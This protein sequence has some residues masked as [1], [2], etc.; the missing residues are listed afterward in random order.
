MKKLILFFIAISLNVCFAQTIN[1]PIPDDFCSSSASSTGFTLTSATS[2]TNGWVHTPKGELH[3]LVLFIANTCNIPDPNWG[4]DPYLPGEINHWSPSFIPNWTMGTSNRLFDATPATIGTTKNLSLFY[5]EM[6]HG[7]FILTGE[8]FPDMIQTPSG[9]LSDAIAYINLNYPNFDWSRFDRRTNFPL[10]N[11]DNSSP[12]VPDGILDYVVVIK[13]EDGF[14]G[15][16]SLDGSYTV[17]TT[18]PGPFSTYTL[19]ASSGHTIA[20]CYNSPNHHQIF[21]KHEFGHNLYHSAHYT[22][23]N[24]GSDGKYYYQSMGWGLMAG[25]HEQFNTTNAWESWWLGWTSPQTITTSGTYNIQDYVTVGDAIRIPVPNTTGEYLWIENH[26][27]IDPN[28]FDGKPF[29]APDPSIPDAQD[30]D[31]GLY[32]Y[33]TKH[34]GDRS[35]PSLMS[36]FSK[37]ACNFIKLYNGEGNFDIKW[38]GLP[39]MAVTGAGE[40]PVFYKDDENPIAGQNSYVRIKYNKIIDDKIEVPYHHGNNPPQP[41]EASEMWAEVIGGIRTATY[42]RT[43]RHNQAFIL[44]SEVGLSGKIPVTNYP[45]YDNVNDILTPYI[46]N[47]LSVKLTGYNS[48]TGTYTLTVNFSDFEVRSDKRWC[49]ALELPPNPTPALPSLIVKTGVTLKVDKGGTPNKKFEIGTGTRDFV[50]P[51]SLNVQEN[52]FVKLESNSNLIVQNNS[53]LKLSP[54]SKLE[55]NQGAILRVKTGSKLIIEG[56]AIIDVL[57]GGRIIIEDDATMDYYQNAQLRLTG[58]SSVCELNG[59]LNIMANSTFTFTSA[60][61]DH[62]YLKFGNS[63]IAPSRNIIAGMNSSINLAGSSTNR[64]VLE[65]AQETFYGPPTLVNF[66]IS[67]GNVVLHPNSRLQA[68][69]LSTAINFTNVRF[70]GNTPGANNGHRGVHLYG[71]SNVTINGCVF[72]FGRYGIYSYMTYGGSPLNVIGSIFRHNNYGIR[73]YDKGLNLI[74]CNFFNNDFGVFCGQMAFPSE[75]IE[76]LVGGGVSNRNTTGIRWSGY[77]T[78]VLTLNNPYVNTNRTGVDVQS[79]PLKVKCGSISYNEVEG[80]LLKAGANLFMDDQVASPNAANVSVFNNGYSIRA[81]NAENLWL[82]KGYNELTPSTINNERTAFGTLFYQSLTIN[83]EA[84][85]W[86]SAGP[87]SASD[88]HLFNASGANYNING[89]VPQASI[90]LCGQA[91][92]PCPTPPCPS[93]SPL[94]YCPACDVINTDDFYYTKLNIATKD[95]IEMLN[96]NTSGKYTEAINLF[97]QILNENYNNPDDKE[98]YLLSLSY[99]KMME[100][101]GNAYKFGEISCSENSLPAIVEKVISVQDKLI[102]IAI[103]NNDYNYRFKYSMDKVQ[104][105]RLACKR[106]ECINLLNDIKTWAVG[107]DDNNAVGLFI[108]EV[109]IEIQVVNGTIK[110]EE[111]EAEMTNCNQSS[112]RVRNETNTIAIAAPAELLQVNLFNNTYSK[113]IDIKTN[114]ETAHLIFYNSIGEII[115]EENINYDYTIETSDLSKGLYLIKITDVNTKEMNTTKVTIN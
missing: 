84:N 11:S 24:A 80:I 72:E 19:G 92:P 51:T 55:V 8:I 107:D 65:I 97:Y 25:W 33:V 94:E 56:G 85:K 66:N 41:E 93:Q 88:F 38:D 30:I 2:S 52:S 15:Y 83:A 26:Q 48:S 58:S 31:P 16:S 103:S 13:R 110:L 29:Y 106:V 10:Y 46:L 14:N 43:G 57:N 18:A 76:G 81:V 61:S 62:G 40:W 100:A 22:G 34:F 115:E 20:K 90:P 37:D 114:A 44:G 113:V 36:G 71:Q 79:C 86:S 21:F 54:G 42:A 108:C 77:S 99:I 101:L 78:P 69:G 89:N 1:F 111:I 7:Q 73:A 104:T 9:S 70:T 12:E 63:T 112:E 39:P 98:K 32:M 17:T 5:R 35:D 96:S 82:Q 50:S 49:G 105:L 74:A 28:S 64:K 91:I 27:K 102:D 95:A 6:S 60:T 4:G 68:D 75:F 45:I 23:S 47:G 109:S 67:G 3:V 59:I 53:T 87:L